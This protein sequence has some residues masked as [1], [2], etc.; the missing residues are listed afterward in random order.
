MTAATTHFRTDARGHDLLQHVLG[1]IESE[2]ATS[3]GTA[4]SAGRWAQGTTARF[5]LAA[6]ADNGIHVDTTRFGNT[7]VTAL[8]T[9][10]AAEG[11]TLDVVGYAVFSAGDALLLGNLVDDFFSPTQVELEDVI[12][13]D[14][15]NQWEPVDVF[16]RAAELLGV[17]HDDLHMLSHQNTT[18]AELRTAVAQI[19]NT[20]LSSAEFS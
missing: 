11:T 16:A 2:A 7:V 9:A 14:G 15:D 10:Y 4:T 3:E 13:S 18:L 12:A 5:S 1:L 8:S 19:T 17:S 20:H 6:L